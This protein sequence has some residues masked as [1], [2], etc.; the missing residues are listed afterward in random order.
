MPAPLTSFDGIGN[1]NGVLPP[2]TQG[3]IGYDPATGTKYYVQW[4][5]VSFAIWDVTGTPTQICGPV[6]GNTLWQGFGGD[7]RD[8]QP[9]RPH[10]PL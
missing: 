3:D 9:R 10:H 2:D 4:V 7:L 5:N 8:H 1:V 6:N